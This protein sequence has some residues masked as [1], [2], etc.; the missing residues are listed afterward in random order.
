MNIENFTCEYLLKEKFLDCELSG[1]AL[2]TWASVYQWLCF[3]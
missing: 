1:Y 2:G 3:L